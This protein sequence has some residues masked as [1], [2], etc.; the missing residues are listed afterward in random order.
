MSF[1][2]FVGCFRDGKK[3]TFQRSVVEEHFG[4]YIT[5][6]QAGWVTL[7]FDDDS[8]SYLYV[9]D[10]VAV[11]GFSINRPVACAKLYEALLSVLKSENLAL[12]MP[13]NCPPLVADAAVAAHLP[14]E[15]ITSLGTPVVLRSWHD[16]SKRID[17][18]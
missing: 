12:Y 15:M 2:L 16:I 1:D 5:A 4:P 10:E 7:T 3:S 9:D 17:E 14:K 18:A 6:R 13:G 11:D 8:R